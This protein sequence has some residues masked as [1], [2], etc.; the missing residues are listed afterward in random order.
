MGSG[1]AGGGPGFL[2]LDP[3]DGQAAAADV[4]AA[5]ARLSSRAAG[6]AEPGDREAGAGDGYAPSTVAHS[7]TVL[8][9]FYDFHR[10]CGTGPVVNP[11]PLDA[12]AGAAGRTRI[13]TRCCDVKSHVMSEYVEG[14]L[15]DVED[16]IRASV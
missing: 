12:A 9:R 11:F 10:E 5:G 1:V 16:V 15:T 3:A 2:L 8:R 7:E 13:T 14:G 6:I 4:P